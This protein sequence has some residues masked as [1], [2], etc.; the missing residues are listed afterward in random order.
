MTHKCAIVNV[1][2][3]GSESGLLIDPYKYSHEELKL[4]TRRFAREFI[5]K[6][7]LSPATNVPTYSMETGQQEMYWIEDT[8]K[9]FHPED[10]NHS[11]CV[12]GKPV[13]HAQ[14][15]SRTQ[16]DL[17]F[18]QKGERFPHREL[19]RRHRKDFARLLRH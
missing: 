19:C 16:R 9:I 14:C 3:G 13:S 10:I 11:G 1:P 8:Y 12:T 7:F 18:K 15:L 17:E 5:R 2:F 4:I 6:G